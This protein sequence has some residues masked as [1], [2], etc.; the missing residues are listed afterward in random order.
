MISNIHLRI[1]FDP[2]FICVGQETSVVVFWCV[3]VEC[4]NFWDCDDFW[5]GIHSLCHRS[6]PKERKCVAVT[7]C[8][9]HFYWGTQHLGWNDKNVLHHN[10]INTTTVQR[11]FILLSLPMTLLL[12]LPLPTVLFLPVTVPIRGW[13]LW[14][15]LC[16]VSFVFLYGSC[17]SS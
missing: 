7:W 17:W 12:P 14:F 13:C 8:T 11:F 2:N 6:G 9:Q 1:E 5:F 15:F 16:H 4:T 3:S 10:N